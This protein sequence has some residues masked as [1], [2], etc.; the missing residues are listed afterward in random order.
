MDDMMRNQIN[1]QA[2]QWLL[3]NYERMKLQEN[4][5]KE[6]INN[7]GKKTTCMSVIGQAKSLYLAG[8]NI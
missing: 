4:E 5:P 3:K 6:P 1:N 2:N 7:R 8:Y